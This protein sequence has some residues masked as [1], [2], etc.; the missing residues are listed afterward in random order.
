MIRD[1]HTN[2]NWPYM[3]RQGNQACHK[4]E[5]DEGPGIPNSTHGAD[6]WT[7]RKAEGEK[8][9]AFVMWGFGSE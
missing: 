7:M 4:S 3:K 9:D 8:F 2:C 5:T 6:N 1:T